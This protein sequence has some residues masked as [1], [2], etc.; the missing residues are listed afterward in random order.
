MYRDISVRKKINVKIYRLSLKYKTNITDTQTFFSFTQTL[1]N[2]ILSKL[3]L[4]KLVL[5][6]I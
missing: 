2:L 3:V 1:S 5:N 4:I 6:L